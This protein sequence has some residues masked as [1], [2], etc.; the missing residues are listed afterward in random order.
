MGLGNLSGAD[1]P[2][3]RHG[4]ASGWIFEW[5]S[6]PLNG[7]SGKSFFAEGRTSV[8]SAAGDCCHRCIG[9]IAATSTG[10]AILLLGAAYQ[11][12][13]HLRL[14]A[15]TGCVVVVVEVDPIFCHA[16]D[17]L[18]YS[19]CTNTFDPGHVRGCIVALLAFTGSPRW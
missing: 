12:V 18:A 9:C 10:A 6:V 11:G 16:S 5:G 17:W 15:L 7:C 2:K 19:Q 14:E 8:L 3:S 1:S 13:R 4:A